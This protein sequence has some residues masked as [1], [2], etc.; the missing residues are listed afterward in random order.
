MLNSFELWAVRW[1]EEDVLVE[2]VT[3]NSEHILA[4]LAALAALAG[5]AAQLVNSVLVNVTS[6]EKG[7]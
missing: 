6:G 2:G 5:L 1:T 7:K 4:A 3:L